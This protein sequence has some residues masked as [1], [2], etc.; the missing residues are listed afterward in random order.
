MVIA[1]VNGKPH[2]NGHASPSLTTGVDDGGRVQGTG[3]FAPGNRLGK[4]FEPGN[5]AGRGNASFRKLAAARS[6][7]DEVLKW[8]GQ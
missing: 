2:V 4:Q 3:R 7:V 6:A 1:S 8:L 5:Q